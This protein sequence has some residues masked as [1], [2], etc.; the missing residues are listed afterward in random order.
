MGNYTHKKKPKPVDKTKPKNQLKRLLGLRCP[1]K[2]ILS[3]AAAMKFNEL[4][5]SYMKKIINFDDL[6]KK[7]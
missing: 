5:I 6:H 3:Y 1:P 7:G 2:D 4:W